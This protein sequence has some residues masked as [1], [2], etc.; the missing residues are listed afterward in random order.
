MPKITKE[1][2]DYYLQQGCGRCKLGGTPQCKVHRWQDQIQLL[3][4]I[5][6]SCNLTETVK[7]GVPCYVYNNKNIV[8]I[9]ALKQQC[10]ISFLNGHLLSN[11]NNLLQKAGINAQKG[12]IIR[13]NNTEEIITHTHAIKAFVLEAITIEK[14]ELKTKADVTLL[15][16]P[17]EFERKMREMP[18]LQIAFYALTPGRQR[19]YI[20]HFNAPKQSKTR[21]ERILKNIPKILS[22]EGFNDAYKK[23]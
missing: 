17:E 23:K 4:N 7:W 2:V 20:I 8:L 9:S 19:G 21:T 6:L 12:R 10:I 14:K 3:R 16:I 11:S 1:S 13:F 5:L 18:A 22:G 15:Q